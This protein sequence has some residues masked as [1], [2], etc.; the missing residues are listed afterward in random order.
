VWTWSFP[1]T[2][3]ILTF[4]FAILYAFSTLVAVATR[5]TIVSILLTLLLWAG[6]FAVNFAYD[7]FHPAP[8]SRTTMVLKDGGFTVEERSVFQPPGAVL[9][10]VD[11]L[12]AVLPRT[13]DLG[14]LNTRLISNELMSDAEQRQRDFETIRKVNWLES[15]GVSLG[16]I[17]VVLGFA[18]WRFARKDF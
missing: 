7:Q 16:F 10:A 13:G 11:S 5:S 1:V 18:C 8:T 4:F 17:A 9:A 15:L 3:L 12:H 14:D 6:L 2:I